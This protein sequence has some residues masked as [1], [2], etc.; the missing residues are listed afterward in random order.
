VQGHQ[1]E[2]PDE[3]RRIGHALSLRCTAGEVAFYNVSH[4][5]SASRP[6][7][8]RSNARPVPTVHGSARD[9]MV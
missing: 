4:G 8:A 6:S 5:T 7:D 2:R 1:V 3:E 9:P